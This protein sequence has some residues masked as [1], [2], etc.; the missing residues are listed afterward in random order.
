MA[1]PSDSP[2]VGTY[3]CDA[4]GSPRSGGMTTQA[5]LRVVRTDDTYVWLEHTG[6]A[7]VVGGD[8]R[9]P[10][11]RHMSTNLIRLYYSTFRLWYVEAP[12]WVTLGLAV[13]QAAREDKQS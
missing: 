8:E 13:H 9:L 4:Y 7:R 2:V 10:S 12:P 5:V 6:R 1:L 3:W 11:I